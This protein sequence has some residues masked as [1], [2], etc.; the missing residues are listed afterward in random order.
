MS[1]SS[2]PAFSIAPP[3]PAYLWVRYSDTEPVEMKVSDCRNISNLKLLVKAALGSLQNTPTELITI[4]ID[5]AS[6]S[7]RVDTTIPSL[8]S[9]EHFTNNLDFPLIVKIRPA[10][11]TAAVLD[12]SIIGIS[13]TVLFKWSA[14][15]FETTFA[16]LERVISTPLSK[17]IRNMCI[18]LFSNELKVFAMDPNPKPRDVRKFFAKVRSVLETNTKMAI[19]NENGL[20]TNGLLGRVPR[21]CT[22]DLWMAVFLADVSEGLK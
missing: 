13:S 9:T 11:P 6:P 7:L 18:K 22:L 4:H 21:C 3:N 2:T 8:F 10:S 19:A 1:K 20:F 5:Q 16:K 12:P 14:E 15:D 17:T